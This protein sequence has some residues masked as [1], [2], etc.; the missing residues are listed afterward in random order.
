MASL[1]RYSTRKH[2]L[3]SQPQPENIRAPV[4]RMPCSPFESESLSP[5]VPYS[6]NVHLAIPFD[7]HER[8]DNDQAYRAIGVGNLSNDADAQRIRLLRL[9][10]NIC[11]E[12]RELI[13]RDAV[14]EWFLQ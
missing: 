7:S 4:I 9:L 13:P 12:A 6:W 10:P 2:F 14:I 5:D 8:T 1:S 3:G 11:S